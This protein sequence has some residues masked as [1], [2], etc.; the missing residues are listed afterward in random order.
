[1]VLHQASPASSFSSL[2]LRTGPDARL[3]GMQEALPSPGH[4]L[5]LRPSFRGA[6]T[7]ILRAKSY[8]PI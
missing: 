2:A 1:M 6:G 7:T 8:A 4:F 3:R 5:L